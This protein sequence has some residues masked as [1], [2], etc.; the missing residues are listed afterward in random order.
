MR[1]PGTNV[2]AGTA[3]GLAVAAPLTLA[4]GWKADKLVSNAVGNLL[5]L[6]VASI[7]P[8]S[9]A[10]YIG[11]VAMLANMGLTGP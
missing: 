7:V 2:P 6:P 9:W 8:K 11:N 3:S 4:A 1:I 5:R 10:P